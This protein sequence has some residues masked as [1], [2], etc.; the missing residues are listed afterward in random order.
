MI[1]MANKRGWLRILEA[2]VAVM[3]ISSVLI[4][5]YSKQASPDDGFS[6][7]VYNLQKQILGDISSNSTL[8]LNVLNTVSNSDSDF[9]S[10]SDFVERKLPDSFDYSIKVCDLD[11]ISCNM[12]NSDYLATM[13]DDV[14]ATEIIV[15]SDLG[16]GSNPVYNPKRLRLFVWEK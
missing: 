15:S 4:F 8:R 10:L 13:H 1:R 3:I 11:V 9:L 14:F 16:D 6:N 12:D 7:Y 5:V 2:T